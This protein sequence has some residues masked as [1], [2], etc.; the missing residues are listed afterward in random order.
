MV[1]K[2]KSW[3]FWDELAK[4]DKSHSGLVAIF[5]RVATSEATK[6]LYLG[7]IKE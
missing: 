2:M 5:C 3:E 4:S 6:E 7:Y 1:I